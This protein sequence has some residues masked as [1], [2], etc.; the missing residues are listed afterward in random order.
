MGISSQ[1][2][3]FLLRFLTVGSTSQIEGV[4]RNVQTAYMSESVTEITFVE[5]HF[6]VAFFPV[7]FLIII[8]KLVSPI[9]ASAAAY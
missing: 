2:E 6:S 3:S 7:T 8:I 4:R 1:I 5:I 9:R